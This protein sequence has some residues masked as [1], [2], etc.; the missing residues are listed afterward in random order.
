MN[1]L[2]QKTFMLNKT[3]DVQLD[4]KTSFISFPD[5]PTLVD[6]LGNSSSIVYVETSVPNS[7]HN[8]ERMCD[9]SGGH[10]V[11]LDSNR[12][13]N[14]LTQKSTLSDFWCGG[15]MCNDSPGNHKEL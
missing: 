4:Y 1:P 6:E 15:N 3:F 10:L 13:E 7:W 8:L 2:Q 14:Q 11:S 5:S 9:N 12:I